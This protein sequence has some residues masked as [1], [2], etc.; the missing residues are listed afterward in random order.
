M[1]AGVKWPPVR[2]VSTNEVVITY[3]D[4]SLKLLSYNFYLFLIDR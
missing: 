3:G 4:F 1:N 2:L